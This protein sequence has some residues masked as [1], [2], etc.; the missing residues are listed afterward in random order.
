MNAE[1]LL[2][3]MESSAISTMNNGA[4]VSSVTGK[5]LFKTKKKKRAFSA[6]FLIVSMI[7]IASLSLG[8]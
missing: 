2:L 4:F 6:L 1:G 5:S 3:K 8:M 7:I